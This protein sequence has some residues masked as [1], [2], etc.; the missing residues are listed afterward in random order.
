MSV[1]PPSMRLP[2]PVLGEH[3]TDILSEAGYSP[4]AIEQLMFEV[5]TGPVAV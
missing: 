4:D 5:W 3:T 1:T 2:P